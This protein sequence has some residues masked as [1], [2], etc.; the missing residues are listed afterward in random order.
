[1]CPERLDVAGICRRDVTTY[2]ALFSDDASLEGH[3]GAHHGKDALAADGGQPGR[4]LATSTLLIVAPGVQP[5]LQ[6]VSAISQLVV[7]IGR[8]AAW[9]IARRS[10][11]SL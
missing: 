5:Q 6:S 2:V 10:V 8:L 7:K 9:R 1:M 4:R 11:H 3:K